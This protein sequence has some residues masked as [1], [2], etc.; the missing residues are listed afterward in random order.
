LPGAGELGN[1]K[2]KADALCKDLLKRIVAIQNFMLLVIFCPPTPLR[3]KTVHLLQR[4]ATEFRERFHIRAERYDFHTPATRASGCVATA[5]IAP[6]LPKVTHTCKITTVF[7]KEPANLFDNAGRGLDAN[8]CPLH[9]MF[10]AN[11]CPSNGLRSSRRLSPQHVCNHREALER[12]DLRT[13][14]EN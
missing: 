2:E 8:G 12:N 10:D 1:A 14:L 7:R 13:Q 4:R 11:G 9:R 6:S 5:D 3:Q